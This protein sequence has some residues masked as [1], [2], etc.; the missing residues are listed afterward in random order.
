MGALAPSVVV[1]GASLLGGPGLADPTADSR[2]SIL[3]LVIDTLRADAVSAY[4]SSEDT[5]PRLDALAG[6]GLLYRRAYAPSPWTLPSHATLFTGLRADEHRTG[7]P[8][9][10]VLPENVSTVAELLGAAG[11]DTAAL[12]ENPIVSDLFQLLQGFEYRRSFSWL[13]KAVPGQPRR[14]VE[15]KVLHELRLWLGQR[16]PSRPYFLFVNLFD[17][18]SPY[19]IRDENRFL[20]PGTDAATVRSRS[21]KPHWLLCAGLPSPKEVAVQRGLYLGDV[22]AADKTAGAIIDLLREQRGADELIIVATSDHGELFGEGRLMGHEFSL[23][24]ALL[25]V[26][27]IVHGLADTPPAIIEQGVGLVDVPPSILRW[28]GLEVPAG[29]SSRPLPQA[30]NEKGEAERGFL[31]AYSDTLKHAPEPWLRGGGKPEDTQTVR[32]FCGPSDPVFGGMA[33]LTRYPHK[34]RWYE[35]YPPELYDLRWD[36]QERSNQATFQREL[37][38]AF[39]AEMEAFVGAAGLVN[40]KNAHPETLSDDAIDALRQ[41]G[42]A[43]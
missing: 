10:G 14:A 24:G 15:F 6:D 2:P 17:P 4:G 1:L 40:P 18:H 29:L 28:A 43:E 25:Q 12:S 38:E 8:G 32:Q 33:S 35:R 36:A 42:Y 37:V 30:A 27:L 22:A 13:G 20:P 3:L 9:L 7:M 16:D 39:T 19:E 5:T 26:P 41:L 21:T 31:A 23:H 34:F 11:Y